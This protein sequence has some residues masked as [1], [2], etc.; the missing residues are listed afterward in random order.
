LPG[1]ALA[2]SLRVGADCIALL[3]LAGCL[4][5]ILLRAIPGV[6][7]MLLCFL[8]AE[9]LMAQPTVAFWLSVMLGLAFLGFGILLEQTLRDAAQMVAVKLIR[10]SVRLR[11]ERI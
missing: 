6:T 7:L 9:G 11:G 1:A 8:L 3:W 2:W 4:R 5:G 10:A